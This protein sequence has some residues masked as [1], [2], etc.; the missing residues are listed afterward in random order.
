MRLTNFL[1][2]ERY[3]TIG[4]RIIFRLISFILSVTKSSTRIQCTPTAC[5]GLFLDG[6]CRQY[7]ANIFCCK[8]IFALKERSNKSVRQITRPLSADNVENLLAQ[9]F[10]WKV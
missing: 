6:V 5:E 4:M 3:N 8:N 1:E 9:I 2:N 10:S 7:P